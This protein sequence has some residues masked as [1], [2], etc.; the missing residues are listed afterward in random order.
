MSAIWFNGELMLWI[1]GFKV[2]FTL[3]K[4]PEQMCK[5]LRAN[6]FG[7]LLLDCAIKDLLHAETE[8]I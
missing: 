1:D 8:S 4:F 2:V 6:L 5:R 3:A 7:K